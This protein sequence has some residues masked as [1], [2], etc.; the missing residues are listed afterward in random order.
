MALLL[1]EAGFDL[2]TTV[3]EKQKLEVENAEANQASVVCQ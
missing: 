1:S 3:L 2:D